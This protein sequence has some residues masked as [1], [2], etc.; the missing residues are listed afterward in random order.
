VGHGDVV[1]I[2]SYNCPGVPRNRLCRQLSGSRRHVEQL[3]AG[4]AGD[5]LHPRA[6]QGSGTGLRGVPRRPGGH[7]NHRP[8]RPPG[9]GDSTGGPGAAGR[10]P[11]RL[12]T[13]GTLPDRCSTEPDDIHRLM[14]TSGTFHLVDHGRRVE[15]SV[16]DGGGPAVTRDVVVRSRA[17]TWRR[18][19]QAKPVSAAVNP[20]S[21]RWARFFHAR[22]AWVIMIPLGRPVPSDP[23]GKILKRELCAR[24]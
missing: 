17:P 24:S 20:N 9:S 16:D 14:Y 10:R 2:L 5:P 11:A 22:L 4:G 1:G 3:A 6:F 15:Q 18:G 7:G 12:Q 13:A 23:S 21:T 19:P 8:G